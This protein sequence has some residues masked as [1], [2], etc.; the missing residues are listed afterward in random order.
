VP[1]G[2]IWFTNNNQNMGYHWAQDFK[3][4]DQVLAC[5]MS[6]I[7]MT[8]LSVITHFFS[9]FHIVP[10]GKTW[11]SC[12]V[13]SKWPVDLWSSKQTIMPMCKHIGPVKFNNLDI[14]KIIW[15]MNIFKY[16]T[17]YHKLGMPFHLRSVLDD[18]LWHIF[19]F[20]MRTTNKLLLVT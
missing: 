15:K 10:H 17:S 8:I 18:R 13:G 20:W 12:H 16:S 14:N 3:N 11:F 5:H 7:S 6:S 9:N 2:M 1:C 4:L 19:D